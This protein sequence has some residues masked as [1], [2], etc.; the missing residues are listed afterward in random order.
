MTDTRAEKLLGDLGIAYEREPEWITEGRKA[1]F[2][3]ATR[4][5]FWCE[6]KTLGELEDQRIRGEAL[7]ELNNRIAG[8]PVRGQAIAYLDG[9]LEPSDAKTIARLAKRAAARFSAGWCIPGWRAMGRRCSR[10][11]RSMST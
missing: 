9:R 8:V 7:A 6:V 1:D 10:D 5:R 2:Y 3:C 4:P 11:Y